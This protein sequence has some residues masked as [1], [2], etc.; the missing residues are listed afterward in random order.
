MLNLGVSEDD[1]SIFTDAPLGFFKI[2]ETP[3]S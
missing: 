1:I 3:L 2:K